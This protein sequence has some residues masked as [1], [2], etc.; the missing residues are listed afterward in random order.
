MRKRILLVV[1]T[2]FTFVS[3]IPAEAADLT[4]AQIVEKSLK[5][6]YYQGKDMKAR[7]SMNL[8]DK[9]GRQRKRTLSILRWDK[10]NSAEQKYFIYFHKPGDVR[11]MTFMVWKHADKN[12]ERWIFIPAVNFVKR[13]AADDKRSSF[14]GS[15]FTYEDISG[16]SASAE[17]H[18]LKDTEVVNDR[19]VYLI[20]STPKEVI[21][22]TKRLSW[23]DRENYLPLKEE[24]YDA[25]QELYKVFTADE[26]AKI[27]DYPTV[28]KRTM[29]NVKTGH[30]TEVSYD[31]T[32]Y[33]LNL[34]EK[35][36]SERNLRKPPRSWIK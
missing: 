15:D 24:F 16:R 31:K 26:V 35:D 33:D 11:G 22:Y 13:I 27:G 1:L 25:Q 8:I 9:K 32:E 14:V 28:T 36:F 21:D 5:E 2:L 29:K 17:T 6:F 3:L 18:V 7:V 19:P 30:K 12:D 23:I 4:A 20:E 34:R 10:E